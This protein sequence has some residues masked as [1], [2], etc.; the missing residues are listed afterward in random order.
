MNIGNEKYI[1][2]YD[3]TRKAYTIA[4]HKDMTP[5]Q[6][7]EVKKLVIAHARERSRMRREKE[8][9]LAK[10]KGFILIVF[11]IFLF[12]LP[13]IICG[14]LFPAFLH[15]DFG[16][17]SVFL[18]LTGAL[19][20]FLFIKLKSFLFKK[21]KEFLMH[22]KE[23]LLKIY[24]KTISVK[25]LERKFQFNIKLYNM[26]KILIVLCLIIAL[27]AIFNPT[28]QSFFFYIKGKEHIYGR[29]EP[30]TYRDKNFLLFSIYR[31]DKI[32]TNNEGE[33]YLGIL[34]NF[35]NID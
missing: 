18:Y 35:Y 20:I 12:Y 19:L 14:Y 30:A 15:T 23:I 16:K 17:R 8:E 11:C 29:Y 32:D 6:K 10:V 22:L 7:E 21:S 27:F 26:K 13:V 28:P 5:E 34:G 9:E 4:G 24:Q 25:P 3:E 2:E 31:F 1:I 33:Y